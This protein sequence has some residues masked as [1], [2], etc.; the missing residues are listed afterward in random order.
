MQPVARQLQQ[1][2]Y[3]NGNEYVF[4]GV[5]AEKLSWRQL[6]GPSELSVES[7]P[8]KTRL[9][10]WSKVAASLGISRLRVEFCTGGSEDRN[11][12]RE[13]EEFPL[14]ATVAR[15]RLVKM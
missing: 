12:A 10:D 9:G 4:Y 7:Q 15:E 5:R 14:L 11:L 1:F 6:V 8:V 13:A 3:N 2:D